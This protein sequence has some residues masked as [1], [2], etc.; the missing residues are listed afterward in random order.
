MS[1]RHNEAKRIVVKKPEEITRNVEEISDGSF[2]KEVRQINREEEVVRQ[3]KF[4]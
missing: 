2:F 4:S 3:E 1:R